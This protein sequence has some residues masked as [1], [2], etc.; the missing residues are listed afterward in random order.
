MADDN[1][2]QTQYSRLNDGQLLKGSH[3]PG[4][5]T[6]GWSHLQT[7]AVALRGFATV[8]FAIRV[9]RA[10]KDDVTLS[11]HSGQSRSPT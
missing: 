3:L 11:S 4:D 1:E 5:Y 7:R 6:F 8:C 10:V 2:L 9:I